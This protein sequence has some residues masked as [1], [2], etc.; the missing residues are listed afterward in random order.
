MLM[1]TW[2]ADIRQERRRY[3]FEERWKG[4]AQ[5]K[6]PGCAASMMKCICAAGNY[7]DGIIASFPT[8]N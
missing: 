3:G 2:E 8:L 5:F 1:E 6:N 7:E 4:K